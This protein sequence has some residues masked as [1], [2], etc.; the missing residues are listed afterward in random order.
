MASAKPNIATEEVSAMDRVPVSSSN[1][2]EVGYEEETMTLEI[3][4]KNGRLYQY[5]EVPASVYTEL[6]AAESPG[7]YFNE[8]IRGAY[9][10]A[11]V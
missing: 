1:L 8:R 5:Y 11:R 4:F 6:V 10:F 3:L 9:R 7:A 2:V